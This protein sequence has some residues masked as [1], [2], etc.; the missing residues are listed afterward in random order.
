MASRWCGKYPCGEV[1]LVDGKPTPLPCLRCRS[2]VRA[3]AEVLQALSGTF[4]CY[5]FARMHGG[6]FTIYEWNED[7][8]GD[9]ALRLHAG[10]G[11]AFLRRECE[12]DFVK[13][14][15]FHMAE[16][17]RPDA[18]V[19]M[20]GSVQPRCGFSGADTAVL[21]LAGPGRLEHLDLAAGTTR[22]L[23]VEVMLQQ[24][25]PQQ[26]AAVDDP[27]GDVCY[28]DSGDLLLCDDA[29][30]EPAF[31]FMSQDNSARRRLRLLIS[32]VVATLKWHRRAAVR[33]GSLLERMDDQRTEDQRTEDPPQIMFQAPAGP[34][35]SGD[36][37]LLPPAVRM[38]DLEAEAL[39]GSDQE[40]KQQR[41]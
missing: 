27:E 31:F 20:V 1:F 7:A 9:F 23:R 29:A 15:E 10:S 19:T 22:D 21:R 24:A 16:W 39:M 2:S 11:R 17:L 4:T 5:A 28:I 6:S 26:K 13:E 3:N 12:S 25:L 32:V 14:R 18:P 40:Q 41:V 30:A 34:L 8:R 36:A 38:R 37:G 35:T 33:T